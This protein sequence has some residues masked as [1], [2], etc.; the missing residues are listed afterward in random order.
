MD[1][2]FTIFW[3]V[4]FVLCSLSYF[5][6]L[7]LNSYRNYKIRR[8]QIQRENYEILL[9]DQKFIEQ[10]KKKVLRP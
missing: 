8:Y 10:W 9:R 4:L 5:S 6:Y 1:E 2:P 3:I 7:I